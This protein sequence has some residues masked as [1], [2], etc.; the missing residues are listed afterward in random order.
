MANIIFNSETQIAIPME[1]EE[2]KLLS[3]AIS[4]YLCWAAGY[5]EAKPEANLF[6]IRELREFN[7]KLKDK[8]EF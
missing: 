2:A 7:L 5:A 4:D 3:L 6:G 8:V 1:K